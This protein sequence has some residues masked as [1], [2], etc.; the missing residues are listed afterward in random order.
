MMH[1]MHDEIIARCRA[2][3][4]GGLTLRLVYQQPGR[5]DWD[6]HV[7]P[8]AIKGGLT[9]DDTILQAWQLAPKVGWRFFKIARIRS[10]RPA[11]PF[12]PRL[13]SL[14]GQELPYLEPRQYAEWTEPVY[15]YRSKLMECLADLEI[16]PEEQ[17]EL[18][19]F[20]KAH[21]ITPA[22]RRGVH[23]SLLCECMEMLLADGLIDDQEVRQISQLQDCLKRATAA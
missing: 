14:G 3:A 1:T 18:E 21:N 13:R 10:I 12:E 15:Q 4:R 22:Q 11:E 23:F 2:A 19:A 20:R 8:Y 16:S 9:D 17:A 6:C 5:E 7:E